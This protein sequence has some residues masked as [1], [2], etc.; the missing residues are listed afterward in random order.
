M[1]PCGGMPHWHVIVLAVVCA[2]ASLELGVAQA[3]ESPE[4][5]KARGQE[6]RL[7]LAAEKAR[8][9]REDPEAS[10]LR[11]QIEKLYRDLDR[12]VSA[13]PTVARLQTDLARLEEA[14]KAQPAP[15]PAAPAPKGRTP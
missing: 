10:A 9:L 11:R 2:A 8:I 7:Q 6:L 13:K 4:T 1:R 12:L 3:A 14:A 5:L 15:P